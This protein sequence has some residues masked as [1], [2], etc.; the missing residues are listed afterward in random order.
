MGGLLGG[1]RSSFMGGFQIFGGIAMLLAENPAG[2]FAIIQG[3]LDFCKKK[4]CQIASGVVGLVGAAGSLTGD[5]IV[6]EGTGGAGSDFKQMAES[7]LIPT[8]GPHLTNVTDDPSIVYSKAWYQNRTGENLSLNKSIFLGGTTSNAEIK[9]ADPYTFYLRDDLLSI[10]VSMENRYGT[11]FHEYVHYGSM[12][13]MGT[14]N[15]FEKVEVFNRLGLTGGAN[16]WE[17]IAEYQGARLAS[18]FLGRPV[19]PNPAYNVEGL[20]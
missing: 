19:R 3:G 10:N 15:Y 13:A 8:L 14:Q 7:S 16:P 5:G 11:L 12:K 18:E 1:Q 6:G 2:L 20:R 4:G 9:S 17:R